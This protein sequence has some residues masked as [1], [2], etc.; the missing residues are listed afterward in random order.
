MNMR[1]GIEMMLD[2][3]HVIELIDSRNVVIST[4]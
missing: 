4:E 3:I 1:K 2:R